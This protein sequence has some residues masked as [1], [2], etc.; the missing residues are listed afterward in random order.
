MISK[1]ISIDIMQYLQT[2]EELSV[3][4]ISKSMGTTPE[5]IE[6][7]ISKKTVLEQKHIE[8]HLKN[9]NTHF[10]EFALKAIKMKHLSKKVKEK[11]LLCEKL[12]KNKKKH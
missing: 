7:V 6:K 3:D 11:V 9:T 5:Y 1:D 4:D 8:T 12:A 2:V 10:W